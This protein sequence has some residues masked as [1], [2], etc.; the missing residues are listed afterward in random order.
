MSFKKHTIHITGAVQGVGFRPFI[1][2]LANSF[3]LKGTVLNSINGVIIEAFGDK[4]V[5]ENFIEKIKSDKPPVSFIK[6]ITLSAEDTD[7]IPGKFEIIHSN[8]EGKPTAYILPDIAACKDCIDEIFN[9]EDR[10]YLYPF[11]NC[12]NCGPRYT[13]IEKLPY[14]RQNTTMKKFVMCGEC[15]SEYEN[16]RDRRFHAQ[17]NAC[18]VCGPRVFLWDKTGKEIS[19]GNDAVI[20]T[21][22]EI[23]NG[24]I[25]AVKGLGGFH[26]FANALDNN[27]VKLLRKRKGREEKPFAM[28]FRDIEMADKYCDLN[29][30]IIKS[31]T[32]VSSPIVLTGR[33]DKAGIPD[34]VNGINSENPYYG[35][36]LPYTPLHHILMNYLN[37]P[38]IATSGNISDE[39]ICIDE[40]EALDRLKN[41]A[42]LFLVHNRPVLRYVDDSILKFVMDDEMILRRSRGYAPIPEITEINSGEDIIATGAHLKNTIAVKKNEE[43]FISQHIGD[44]ENL[45]SI[46]AFTKTIDDFTRIYQVKPGKISC[47]MHPDYESTKY[48]VQCESADMK[49]TKVQHHIAHIFSCKA[50]NNIQFPF[51][52]VAWDGTG[53]GEDGAVW[54][55]EFFIADNDGVKRIAHLKYFKLPGGEEAIKKVYRISA[56]LLY[57]MNDYEKADLIFNYGKDMQI[58]K[59]FRLINSMLNRGINAPVT[60]SM[61]RLFDAVAAFLKIKTV[62]AF[63]GQAAME[64]EFSIGNFKTD[65]FYK[66]GLAEENDKYVIDWIPLIKDILKDISEKTSTPEIS[67]KFHN[68]LTEVILEIAKKI[69]FERI[70]LSG[71]CFQNT[72]LLEHTIVKLRNS[73]FQPYW[74]KKNPVNDGG[75]SLGQ[76]AYTEYIMNQKKMSV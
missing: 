6:K 14:D 5:I 1:Y 54:G 69:N 59:E 53:Y 30:R 64:L 8:S 18:P 43:I 40:F 45:Q 57:E 3:N 48:A 11:T 37:I 60:S 49:L 68:T 16:P 63:E 39:P 7:N 75:I 31:L 27:T 26:L 33:K 65:K 17:P 44:L 42:D 62:S 61:G 76:I 20:K 21:S 22:E 52:G 29:P 51:L 58:S 9:P 28:M 38:V 73:G 55:S 13:I 12:T 36:L 25:I 24:K 19:N 15:R 72:Y 2:N 4:T 50:E 71:G 41:I 56:S 35:I 66:Y 74:Q 67:A 32:S 47:D 70:A 34:F 10:R 23:L 46:N